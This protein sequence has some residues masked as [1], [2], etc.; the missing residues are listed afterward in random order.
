MNQVELV[1]RSTE[2]F[3]PPQR[4]QFEVAGSKP[5]LGKPK[6]TIEGDVMTI[7][8]SVSMSELASL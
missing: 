5:I 4:A 2:H 7:V 6:V 3:M 1:E 8:A